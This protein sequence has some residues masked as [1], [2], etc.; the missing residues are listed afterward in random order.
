M[1]R[2]EGVD[3]L[4]MRS[5]FITRDYKFSTRK[6]SN[7]A[8]VLQKGC[9]IATPSS[10]RTKTPLIGKFFFT[11]ALRVSLFGRRTAIEDLL[12]GDLQG[13]R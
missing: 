13:A 3:G 4:I 5:P 12:G 2:Y 10:R 7:K 1:V 9:P 8:V 11:K 6:Q